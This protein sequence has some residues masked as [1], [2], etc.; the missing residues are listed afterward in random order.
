[1]VAPGVD[2]TMRAYREAIRRQ[3]ALRERG[4]PDSEETLGQAMDLAIIDVA[5][6]VAGA[7]LNIEATQDARAVA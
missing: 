6:D 2:R 1:M 5:L 3:S 4:I 7:E